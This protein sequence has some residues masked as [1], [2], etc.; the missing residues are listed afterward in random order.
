[1]PLFPP[2][3]VAKLKHEIEDLDAVVAAANEKWAARN[4]FN[5]ADMAYSDAVA[6]VGKQ[7]AYLK[8]LID[9]AGGDDPTP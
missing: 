7:Q 5:A 1:M 3:D 9:N 4:A 6:L 8:G 2:P